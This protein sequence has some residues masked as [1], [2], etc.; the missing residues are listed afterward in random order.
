M[1]VGGRFAIKSRK[2][3]GIIIFLSP[4]LEGGNRMEW[5]LIKR[6]ILKYSSLPLFGSFNGGNRKLILLFE[7]LSRRE[8]NG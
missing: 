7:N 3:F 5:K 8:W 6:I 4:H 1:E 2:I